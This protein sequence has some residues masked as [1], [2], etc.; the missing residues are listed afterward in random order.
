MP[1]STAALVAAAVF[2]AA[3]GTT[4]TGC[5]PVVVA[6]GVGAGVMVATD[7]RTTGSQVDDESI[8]FTISTEADKR[9]GDG[10]H[11]N[12]TSYNGIVLLT[13]EAPSTTV[14][15]EIAAFAKGVEHVRSVQNEMTIGEVTDMTSRTNDTYLTGIVK[16]R[17][18]ES[19]A[20]L[21]KYVKVVTERAVVYLMGIVT[22]DEGNTAA[23]IAASTSGVARVVK[24]FEYTN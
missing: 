6:A 5:A 8:E 22:V 2:V 17:L 3:A 9:W 12:A 19:S 15:D 10:V 21:A 23:Q 4:L 1:A 7:R 16:S 20:A 24:V 18:A 13:G 11:L 14:Q